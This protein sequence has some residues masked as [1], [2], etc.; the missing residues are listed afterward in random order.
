MAIE[1]STDSEQATG[2]DT[3][4]MRDEGRWRF[5]PEVNL[6]AVIQAAIVLVALISWAAT[7]N[8]RSDQTRADVVQLRAETAQQSKELRDTISQQLT[9]LRTELRTLPDQRARLEGLE[10]WV[11]QHDTA[12]SQE[13]R[14]LDDLAGQLSDL[15]ATVGT[16]NGRLGTIGDTL[17]RPLRTVR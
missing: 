13:R 14:Q 9:D 11:Q 7:A 2:T 3:R 16:V 1:P 6:G 5:V 17:N 10:R 4:R 8:T 15:R 12:V